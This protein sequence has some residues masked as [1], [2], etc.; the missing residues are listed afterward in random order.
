MTWKGVQSKL[1]EYLPETLGRTRQQ[2]ED[3]VHE[4]RLVRSALDEIL[5]PG[6]WRTEAREAKSGPPRPVRW[7]IETETAK[8]RSDSV[9]D[10]PADWLSEDEDSPPPEDGLF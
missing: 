8:R 9:P 4:Q 2:R 1:A 6:G 5:G 3:W 7:I 10:L